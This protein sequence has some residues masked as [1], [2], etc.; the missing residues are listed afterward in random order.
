M[1]LFLINARDKA[2]SVELRLAHRE[3]HLAWAGTFTD[4]IAM[5]GPVFRDDG[6]R[7]AGSTFVIEFETLADAQNWAASDPYAKAD[8][9]ETVEI[10]PFRWLLGH[11]PN[12]EL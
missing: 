3:A 6:T 5:A 12:P 2:D 10:L 11:G 4:R 7:M 1:P 8:L 9:F